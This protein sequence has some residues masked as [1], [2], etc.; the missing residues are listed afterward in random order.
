MNEDALWCLPTA[1][2]KML[3][4][5]DYTSAKVVAMQHNLSIHA[6][7]IETKR[8]TCCYHS[9]SNLRKCTESTDAVKS[10]LRNQVFPI[11][12]KKK[13]ITTI[14]IPITKHYTKPTKCPLKLMFVFVREK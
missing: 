3:C 12:K 9:N 14:I 8:Q 6:K 10:Q 13:T 2:R 5:H 1:T 4:N 7:W 11:Y